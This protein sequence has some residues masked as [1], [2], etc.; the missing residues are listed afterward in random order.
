MRIKLPILSYVVF[1]FALIV[2]YSCNSEAVSV[3]L[4]PVLATNVTTLITQNT[5]ISGGNI[6][7]DNGFKVTTRGVCWSL[8]SNPTI[9]DSLTSDSTGTGAFT[10]LIKNLIPDTTYYVRAYATNKNGTAYGLQETFRTLSI[11]LPVIATTAVS[12]ITA[13]T[14]TSGGNITSDGG[15][16][17]IARGVCWNTSPNPTINNYRI[18]AGS[19]TGAFA[20]TL[21]NLSNIC[22]VRAYASNSAGISYGNQLVFAVVGPDSMVTDVDGNVYHAVAIGTQVWMVENLK[23]TKYNDGTAIPLVT[24]STE[25]AEVT[26]P[27][28]CWYNDATTFKNKYGALYNWYT[29]NTAKL[30]PKG[31]HIPTDTE[32]TTLTDYVTTNL[33]YSLNVAKA[34]AATTDWNTNSTTG[35]V[36]NNLTLNNSTG[37]SALPCGDRVS[38]GTFYNHGDGGYWW[39]STE[40]DTGYAWLR[41]MTYFES[42]VLRSS[43]D[44]RAGVSVRCIRDSQ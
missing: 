12:D 19:G 41:Y 35:G 5:A 1:L 4:L 39:C 16:V 6:S 42:S 23:T 33:G 20:S 3:K 38:D 28:F 9:K 30:A 36:G 18:Q 26:T 8:K 13:T 27:A 22:Y 43:G 29:V 25:W 2:A 21:T 17:I 37:F 40:L 14:A 32:W 44:K 24:N 34:L 7:S 31:W 10:S 15:S 11:K